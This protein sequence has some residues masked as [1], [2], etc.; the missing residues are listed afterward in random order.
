MNWV[1]LR[2]LLIVSGLTSMT[3]GFWRLFHVH[4]LGR[5]LMRLSGRGALTRQPGGPTPD[6]FMA[7]RPY[8]Y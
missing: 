1:V 7:Q 2:D 6:G 4:G 5:L 8:R 3:I